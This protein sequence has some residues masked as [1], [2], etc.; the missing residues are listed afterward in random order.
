MDQTIFVQKDSHKSIIIGKLGEKIKEIGSRARPE[1]EKILSS[2]VLLRINVLKK[3]KMKLEDEGLYLFGK[4]HGERFVI[5]N[6]LS[7][8]N[9]LIKGLY[10]ISKKKL[11]LVNL[12]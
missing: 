11:F 9:G 2:K 6:I 3:S 7:K 12:I 1:I 4:K 5:L 10:R 8:N